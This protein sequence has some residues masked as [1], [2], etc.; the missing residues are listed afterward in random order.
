MDRNELVQGLTTYFAEQGHEVKP[1]DD[2]FHG[3]VVDSMGILD[4]IEFIE[5]RFS[6]EIPQE[7]MVKDNLS[8]IDNIA[9][10]L[11]SLQ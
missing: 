10:M 5:D 4:L 7:K 3:N 2:L 1:E 11:E 6:I 9:A 8:S